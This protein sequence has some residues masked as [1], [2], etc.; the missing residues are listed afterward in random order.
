LIS[1][2]SLL[3]APILPPS[4]FPWPG[5]QITQAR[6]GTGQSGTNSE[7]GDL[8]LT[9][10]PPTQVSHRLAR[11][12]TGQQTRSLLTHMMTGVP[13]SASG[14]LE[15]SATSQLSQSLFKSGLG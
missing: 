2:E 3:A 1:M 4:S 9:C 14:P 6:A 8:D 10:A 13:I 5:L 7:A 12:E 11:R 15:L